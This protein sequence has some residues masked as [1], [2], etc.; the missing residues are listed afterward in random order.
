MSS[1]INL[2]A[3]HEREVVLGSQALILGATVL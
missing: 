2:Y 1:M 3:N